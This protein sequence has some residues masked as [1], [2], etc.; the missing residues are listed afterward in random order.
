MKL[1]VNETS[2][3]RSSVARLHA[4]SFRTFAYWH[5][6]L[7]T[8]CDAPVQCESVYEIMKLGNGVDDGGWPAESL[9]AVLGP[10]QL[11]FQKVGLLIA[12]PLGSKAREV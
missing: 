1:E 12:L 11:S 2:P 5:L 8:H 10:T 3:E 6:L 4:V 7:H 9:T